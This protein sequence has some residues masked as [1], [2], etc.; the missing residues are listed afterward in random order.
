MREKKHCGRERNSKVPCAWLEEQG[1]GRGG[2][3]GPVYVSKRLQTSVDAGAG[4]VRDLVVNTTEG[5]KQ[6]DSEGDRP[7]GVG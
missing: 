1:G 2:D 7:D 4:S 3:G 6:G 5:R